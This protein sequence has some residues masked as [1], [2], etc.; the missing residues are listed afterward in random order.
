MDNALFKDLP[1][2][3]VNFRKK[4]L[5]HEVEKFNYITWYGNGILPKRK[6]V[7]L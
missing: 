2:A 5:F 7:I 4:V 3:S 6:G 1:D